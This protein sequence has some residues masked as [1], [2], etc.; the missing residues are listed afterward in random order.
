VALPN[1]GDSNT[2]SRW[3]PDA[4][5]V[6]DLTGL[7]KLSGAIDA[8]S[9]WVGQKLSWLVL[10][11]VLVSATN[12]TVRK[13]F[14]V[15]SNAWLELQWVL[16]SA[17]FLVGASWTLL[18][19]EHIRIDIVNNLLPKRV[20]DRIDL[21]GHAFFLLPLTIVMLVTAL[22]F[23][24]ASFALNEQSGNAGGLPQWPAKSLV[25]IGFALLFA[26]GVSELIKRIAV[27]RGLIDDPHAGGGGLHAAAEAEAA[28][29]LA[30]A[31]ADTE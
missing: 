22:P 20:R 12:A 21:V 23:F 7:L 13:L 27:M 18:E 6:K 5:G 17:I 26:Q 3:Q 30:A 1:R 28:R 8:V 29:V 31:K 24:L 4:A 11:A 25:V 10:A 9:R 14:G 2:A 19:N 15:S 16:F